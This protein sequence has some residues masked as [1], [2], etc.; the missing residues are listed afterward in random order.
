MNV[1]VNESSNKQK[2]PGQFVPGS[3]SSGSES[4]KELKFQGMKVLGSYWNFC[5]LDQIGLRVKKRLVILFTYLPQEVHRTV[6][7][8]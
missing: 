8:N 6:C 1:A 7:V 2:F 3:K 5:C 4:S